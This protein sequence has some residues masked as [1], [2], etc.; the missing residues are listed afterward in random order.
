MYSVKTMGY[1]LQ[2]YGIYLSIGYIKQKLRNVLGKIMG[3]TGKRLW[4]ILWDIFAKSYGIY[5]RGILGK[6]MSCIMG[7]NRQYFLNNWIY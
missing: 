6:P 7:Y 2:N 5:L 4:D 1:I 3:Y